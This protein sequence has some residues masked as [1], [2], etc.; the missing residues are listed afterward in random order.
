MHQYRRIGDSLALAIDIIYTCHPF[1]GM[2]NKKE[3]E[4]VIFL[5]VEVGHVVWLRYIQEPMSFFAG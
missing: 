5:V 1:F 3:M 2:A 4:T